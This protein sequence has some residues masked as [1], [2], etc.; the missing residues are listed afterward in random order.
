MQTTLNVNESDLIRKA[1]KLIGIL[2]YE[3]LSYKKPC[4]TIYMKLIEKI[5][6]L[7]NVGILVD[8]SSLS[9]ESNRFGG[10]GGGGNRKTYGFEADFDDEDGDND[11][12]QEN[13]FIV[14]SRVVDGLD[15]L[16]EL[17]LD[18]FEI[19]KSLLQSAHNKNK[20]NNNKK[21]KSYR[22]SLNERDELYERFMDLV[23]LLK[24]YVEAYTIVFKFLLESFEHLTQIS[25]NFFFAS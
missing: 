1:F 22:L 11:E 15:Q 18:K 10:G 24:P 2:Q 7:K 14:D 19:E 16:S 5:L 13:E 8:E 21:S 23:K 12:Q 4:E 20:P 3:F 6:E 9:G 17:N 25:G